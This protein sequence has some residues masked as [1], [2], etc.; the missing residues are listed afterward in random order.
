MDLDGSPAASGHFTCVR[1]GSVS[2]SAHK[3]GRLVLL[4]FSMVGAG[5]CVNGL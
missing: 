1:V 4:S 3:V 2:V 5:T